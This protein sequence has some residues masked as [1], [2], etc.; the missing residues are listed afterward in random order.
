MD[1]VWYWLVAVCVVLAASGALLALFVGP[2]LE[3]KHACD[4]KRAEQLPVAEARS[5][6]DAQ[7][8]PLLERSGVC[9]EADRWRDTSCAWRAFFETLHSLRPCRNYS[10]HPSSFAVFKFAL[11]ALALA[12]IGSMLGLGRA[13]VGA[14]IYSTSLPT[15]GAASA[16]ASGGGGWGYG[17]P[18]YGGGGSGK[19]LYAQQQQ[20]QPPHAD[21][22]YSDSGRVKFD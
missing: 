16:A 21:V 15:S 9:I 3:A 7:E 2:Y 6:R 4:A 10:C 13:L 20:Q 22:M 17:M 11:L 14:H 12:S 1:S 18:M 19:P 5:C 8:R